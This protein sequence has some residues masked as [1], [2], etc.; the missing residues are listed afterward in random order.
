MAL[1]IAIGNTATTF[2]N[3]E[4]TVVAGSPAS[5]FITATG[6]VGIPSGVRFEIAFKTAGGGYTVMWTLDATNCLERGTI[7]PPAT[8]AVRRLASTTG[9]AGLELKA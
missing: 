4:F 1:P 3:G 5:L 6:D 8:Y 2:A 9:S 7:T